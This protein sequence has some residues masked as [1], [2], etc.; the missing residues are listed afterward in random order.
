MSNIPPAFGPLVETCVQ[1]GISRTVAFEL[2]R[3]GLLDTFTIG[4]RRYVNL[5][6]L[7]TLP[8]RLRDLGR[9]A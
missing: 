9:A 4:T 5:D 7:R 8:E 1:H 3:K 2:A 6:S